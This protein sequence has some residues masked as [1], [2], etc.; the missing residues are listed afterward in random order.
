MHT[1]LVRLSTFSS[2]CTKTYHIQSLPETFSFHE[3]MHGLEFHFCLLFSL[4]HDGDDGSG[5]CAGKID[6]HE[7]RSL[8]CT[9]CTFSRFGCRIEWQALFF[10]ALFSSL[11][12]ELNEEMS[13][14]SGVYEILISCP[15]SQRAV[16]VCVSSHGSTPGIV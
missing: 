10:L 5:C 16:H 7:L 6:S 14:D 4:S 2:N 3:E 13:K 8:R 1:C 9:S 12:H 11:S 15:K